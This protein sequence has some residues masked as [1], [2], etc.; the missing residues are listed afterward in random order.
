MLNLLATVAP[1]PEQTVAQF[2]GDIAVNFGA[3]A[4][5]GA[6]ITVL[7]MYV[8]TLVAKKKDNADQ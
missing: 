6:A 2:L 1:A 4:A 3:P 5:V 7:A 8:W